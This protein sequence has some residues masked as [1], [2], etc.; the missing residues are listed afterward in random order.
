MMVH[1]EDGPK[2]YWTYLPGTDRRHR[3]SGCECSK[4]QRVTNSM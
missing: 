2:E 4:T 3:V 1:R